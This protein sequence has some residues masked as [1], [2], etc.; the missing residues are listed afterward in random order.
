M[1]FKCPKATEPLQ[2]DSLLSIIQFPK[3]P[4]TQFIDLNYE[5][6]LMAKVKRLQLDKAF[7][8]TVSRTL[9]KV[10]NSL[11]SSYRNNIFS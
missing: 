6:I 5:V 11:S 7:L 2:G 8:Q 10:R 3:V 9:K 1:W 4:G